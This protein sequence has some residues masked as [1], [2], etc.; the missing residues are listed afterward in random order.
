MNAL[1]T[2]GLGRLVN[3]AVRDMG[4]V[5]VTDVGLIIVSAGIPESMSSSKISSKEVAYH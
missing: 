3:A 5:V 2:L 4:N 1:L